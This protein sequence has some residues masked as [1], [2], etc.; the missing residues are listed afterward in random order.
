MLK[1]LIEKLEPDIAGHLE[2]LGVEL[3]AVTFGWFLSLFT[4]SL[5]I[6][7]SLPS[8]QCEIQAEAFDFADLTV[9]RLRLVDSGS[10]VFADMAHS[11][12]ESGI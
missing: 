7:V 2:D 3:P 10:K 9:R 1:D 12:D 4:D 6:Q 5:P 11:A 8:V